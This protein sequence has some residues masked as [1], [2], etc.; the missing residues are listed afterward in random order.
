MEAHRMDVE[1]ARHHKP[2]IVDETRASARLEQ[3]R[4]GENL[5]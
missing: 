2:V 3:M 1:A 4:C 5:G